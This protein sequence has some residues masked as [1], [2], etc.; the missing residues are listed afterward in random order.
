MRKRRRWQRQCRVNWSSTPLDCSAIGDSKTNG[1]NMRCRSY[2]NKT[3]TKHDT[4][5]LCL[6]DTPSGTAFRSPLP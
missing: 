3:L 6:D 5:G 2:D 4:S 1:T